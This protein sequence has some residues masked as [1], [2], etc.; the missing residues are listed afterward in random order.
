MS[1]PHLDMECKTCK[2]KGVTETKHKKPKKTPCTT[3]EGRGR[4]LTP[5][6]EEL[7]RIFRLYAYDELYSLIDRQVTGHEDAFHND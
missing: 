6:G 3:C 1:L 5:E 7:I 2:G 4:N